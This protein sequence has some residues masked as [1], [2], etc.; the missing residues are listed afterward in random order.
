MLSSLYTAVSGMSANG[1]SLSVTADNISNV[2]TV[3]FKRSTTSFGDVLS[4][5][6]SGS[7]QVGRGVLISD[8]TPLFTQGSLETTENVLDLAIDGEGFFI[9]TD[10]ST[11]YYTRAGEFTTYKDGR[12]VNSDGL[13]LQGYVVDSSGNISGTL[14]DLKVSSAMSS[15]KNTDN[16]EIAVNL[17]SAEA[18]PAA[19]FTL[20]GN[21][22][23]TNDDPE[24]Y[25]SS[26]T[27]TIYDSQGGDHQVTLYFTKTADNAWE[28]H[29]VYADSANPGQLVESTSGAQALTFG[30]DGTLTDDNSGTAIDFDFGAAITTPQSIYFNYG[31]GTG[32]ATPGDGMDGTTQYAS[33][34]SVTNVTQ[35]GYSAGS[36]K[37]I[38]IAEDG[39][40]TGVFTNG[41]T[42]DIGQV[43]LA[44]FMSNSNL[45]REG[46]NLYTASS[47]SGQ[48]L[49]GLPE[50][51][52][53]GRLLSNTLELSNIDLAEEFVNMITAQRGF[54]ANSKVITTTDELLQEVVNLKR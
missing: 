50:T 6:I 48:A 33:D 5:T 19:A 26:S 42:K 15:A 38:N 7:M 47:S 4:Q 22:D 3:G 46:R 11:Q 44:R 39:T 52:G 27:V 14:G 21:G 16:A 35:D 25:N 8:I 2:N 45:I 53:L 32:E 51:S 10:G 9:V 43:A 54:Q 28:V 18:V 41:Q 37:S 31:T 23:G 40:I 13:V 12:I 34:F 36:L 1:T 17:D 24:N 20:D 30:T 29:Y 49:I